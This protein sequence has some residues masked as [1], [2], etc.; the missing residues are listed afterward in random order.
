MKLCSHMATVGPV[1]FG[2]DIMQ[3]RLLQSWF[4][5][6]SFTDLVLAV[7]VVSRVCG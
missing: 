4:R 5:S 3:K 2:G 7:P 1:G 6:R